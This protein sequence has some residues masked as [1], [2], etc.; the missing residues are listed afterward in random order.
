MSSHQTAQNLLI[1]AFHIAQIAAETILIQLFAGLAVPETA[2]IRGNLVGKHDASIE[3]AELEL[4]VNQ[5]N[6]QILR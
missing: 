4:E 3:T 6:A 1:R 5:L 2:G